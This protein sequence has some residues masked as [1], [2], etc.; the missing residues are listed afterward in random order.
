MEKSVKSD[1][2]Y[3]K[4]RNK[5]GFKTEYLYLLAIRGKGK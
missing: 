3:G 4:V 2:F 5:F 1:F